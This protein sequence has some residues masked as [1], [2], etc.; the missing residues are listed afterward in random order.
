MA[1]KARGER[2]QGARRTQEAKKCAPLHES[3]LDWRSA[4][5]SLFQS[6]IGV[7]CMIVVYLIYVLA[8]DGVVMHNYSSS[9]AYAILMKL[10][11]ST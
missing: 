8:P 5:T 3:F 4:V 9:I 2:E 7:Q 10:P 1:E 11:V 6:M